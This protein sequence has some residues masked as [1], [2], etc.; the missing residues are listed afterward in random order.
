MG[1]KLSD[2]S[3]M[4]LYLQEDV[5][6]N[7]CEWDFMYNYIISYVHATVLCVLNTWV[8][9]KLLFSFKCQ[10]WIERSVKSVQI[11]SLNW[12]C[13]IPHVSRVETKM[14]FSTFCEN[15]KISRYFFRFNNTS[16]SFIL[17]KFFFTKP[18][19]SAQS[20]QIFAKIIANVFPK[21]Q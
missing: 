4:I 12:Y 7:L 16:Q 10:P 17:W 9:K 2:I 15:A 8:E 20:T 18:H 1:K 6:I 11:T 13:L 5:I 19:A 21:N 14:H 3:D